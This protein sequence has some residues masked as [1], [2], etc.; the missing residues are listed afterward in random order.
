M[1]ARSARGPRRL[2]HRARA[3]L[4]DIG[5]APYLADPM[6]EALQSGDVAG[7]LPAASAESDKYARGVVGVV[8][9]SEAYTGAAVLCTGGAL[10]GGAGMVRY[11]GPPHPTEIV[12]NR[13]PEVVLGRAAARPGSSG[14]GWDRRT[15]PEI[16]C[17]TCS[18]RMCRYSS[19]PMG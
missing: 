19:T 12:R 5:L 1:E 14:P 10:A 11:A 17:G 2:A 8:A 13:W 7:L 9:G 3:E 16:G 18:P 6:V 4:V 15:T